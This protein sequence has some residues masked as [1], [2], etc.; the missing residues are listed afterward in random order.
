MSE[1]SK[2]LSALEQGDSFAADRLFPLVYDELR[3]MARDK[4]NL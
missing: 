1:V 3:Q 4:L 2:I